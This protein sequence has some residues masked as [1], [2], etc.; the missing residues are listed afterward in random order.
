MY[1][2]GESAR[3]KNSPYFWITL[4]ANF[5]SFSFTKSPRSKCRRT[6][7][8]ERGSEV[9]A[10]GVVL[11]ICHQPKRSSYA[12]ELT[13]PSFPRNDAAKWFFLLFRRLSEGPWGWKEAPPPNQGSRRNFLIAHLRIFGGVELR[14]SLIAKKTTKSKIQ[15]EEYLEIWDCC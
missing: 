7:E 6:P 9:S 11:S 8:G 3:K 10:S 14:G 4:C 2:A 5:F 12:R 15:H 13:Q 1:V